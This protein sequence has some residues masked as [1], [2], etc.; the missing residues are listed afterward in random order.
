[1]DWNSADDGDDAFFEWA[2]AHF[3]E[4]AVIF[5]GPPADNVP[6]E[7]DATEGASAR[8]KSLNQLN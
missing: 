6:G 8:R 7:V 2:L 1:M 5:S 3:R 4:N